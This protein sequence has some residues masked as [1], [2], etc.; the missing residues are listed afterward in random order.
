MI[1]LNTTFFIQLVNFLLLL[2]ILNFV[3]YRPIRGILKKRKEHYNQSIH[4]TENFC[5][6]AKEQVRTYQEQL[7]QAHQNAMEKRQELKDRA[8]QEEQTL[9]SEAGKS[10]ADSLQTAKQRIAT[11]Q[12]EALSILQA[13]IQNYAH[14]AAQKIVNQA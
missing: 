14:S 11:E 13:Q 6:Q 10:A 8:Y 9:L 7:G 2:C 12:N 3:L 5:T 4:E 1:E